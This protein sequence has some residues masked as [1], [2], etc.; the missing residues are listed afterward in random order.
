MEKSEEEISKLRALLF[1]KVD[2]VNRIK[3]EESYKAIKPLRQR[4]KE[5][6]LIYNQVK[7]HQQEAFFNK[8]VNRWAELKHDKDLQEQLFNEF[9]VEFAED[10]IY[11]IRE[12]MENKGYIYP[13]SANKYLVAS[14]IYKDCDQEELGK[15]IPKK[16]EEF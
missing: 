3:A 4:M 8:T 6:K 9:W 15:R 10:R 1:K 16:A 5:S 11:S 7:K 14:Q 12:F 2:N 13:E